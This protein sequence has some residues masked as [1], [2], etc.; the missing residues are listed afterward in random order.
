MPR[1]DNF[2]FGRIENI[3]DDIPDKDWASTL[4]YLLPTP[5]ELRYLQYKENLEK[6]TERYYASILPLLLI[7]KQES[8][9]LRKVKK[10]SEI[11]QGV[12]GIL[13]NMDM[14]YSGR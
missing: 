2:L 3:K 14:Y 4:N 1:K 7:P 11:N 8:S 9:F 6:A 12:H 13:K 10:S 5:E